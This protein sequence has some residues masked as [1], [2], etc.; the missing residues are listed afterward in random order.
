MNINDDTFLK[1]IAITGVIL[2]FAV[3]GFIMFLVSQF[4]D[5]DRA[6]LLGSELGKYYFYYL[7][8]LVLA[9][10]AWRLIEELKIKKKR[11]GGHTQTLHR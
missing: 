2:P 5:A 8:F 7:G 4:K 1:R 9:L 3:I 6:V 10:V 11:H